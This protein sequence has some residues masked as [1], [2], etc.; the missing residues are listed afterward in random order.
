MENAF[1]LQ[2]FDLPQLDLQTAR[3]ITR[4]QRSQPDKAAARDPARAP[5]WD[6][7]VNFRRERNLAQAGP[8]LANPYRPARPLAQKAVAQVT[9]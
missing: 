1:S 5:P 2:H 3:L 9:S 7:I 6:G 4:N 8:G